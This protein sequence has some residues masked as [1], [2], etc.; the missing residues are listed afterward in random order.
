MPFYSPK[1]SD[2][3]QPLGKS[4]AWLVLLFILGIASAICLF[5][6]IQKLY[7]RLAYSPTTTLNPQP[8]HKISGIGRD[9]VYDLSGSEA[10]GYGNAM[11]LFDENADPANGIAPTAKTSPLPWARPNLYYQKDKGLRI[12]ID[13]QAIHNL[14]EIYYYDRSPVGDSIW[15][16]TGSMREWKLE[17]AC[18]TIGAPASWGWRHFSAHSQTRYLM[19]R[20]NSPKADL[21]ELVLYGNPLEK[22]EKT[23][24][25]LLTGLDREPSLQEFAGTNTYDYVPPPLLKYF[26]KI[27]LYRMMDYFDRDTIQQ[28]P[29]NPI[30]LNHDGLPAGKQFTDYLDSLRK[31][32]GNEL[33]MSVRGL[34]LSQIKKGHKEQEKPV[35]QDG[36]DT[37]NPISYSRHAR[38]FWNIAAIFGRQAQDSNQLDVTDIPKR[39]GL[40][41]MQRIENG[42]EEDG[43]WSNNYW[44]PMD[45]FALSTAD[46]DGAEGKLG[47]KTGIK[48]ADPGFQLMTSGMIQLDTNRVRT[49]KFLCEQ[50]RTD[51]KFIW[52][53]GVQYHYYSNDGIMA[54]REASTGISPEEDSL[55]SKLSRVRAFHDRILPGIPLI[56]GENGYDRKQ[57]SWQR[58]P[59]IPGYNE[60]QSQGIM[61]I[62]SMIAVFMARFDGYN[63]FMM[64]SASNDE[65]ASGTFATSGMI[66][67]PANPII[68]PAW[69]YWATVMQ[70]LG[71]FKPDGIVSEAGPVW[72]YK[73][74]NC[75]NPKQI[76]YI[77]FSPTHNGSLIKNF[78]LKPEENGYQQF[79]E[80]VLKDKSVNGLK[81]TR[82][83][84]DGFM[85]L[86]IG[87]SPTIVILK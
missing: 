12:V 54:I 1:I 43:W 73:L 61:V 24:Q 33:W 9:F 52:E 39:S 48:Q 64:R 71:S 49:L 14:T 70:N 5:Y 6:G 60:G 57:S 27:R 50:L 11:N 46:F 78:R 36:M 8:L 23:A 44:T 85:R 62:R 83:L 32:S 63:Q 68:Y 26:P 69:Y 87:E 17:K 67:G 13:L 25:P 4:N 55:R 7:Y 45:Y 42:N 51:K 47:P 22:I 19:L 84:E 29:K 16:Y 34:P 56:L 77:L 53:G 31:Q 10:S 74:R 75:N 76:A 20:F 2:S 40:N 37:E 41:L 65:N 18:K 66:G 15:F 59:L 3:H 28:Y 81:I 38:T 82:P 80:I 35:N 58:T 79:D 21:T 30:S 72:I 86:N